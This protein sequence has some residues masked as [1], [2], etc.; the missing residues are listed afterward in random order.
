M[1]RTARRSCP[2]RWRSGQESTRRRGRACPWPVGGAAERDVTHQI[3]DL[4]EALLVETGA[5]EIPRQHALERRVV[6]LDRSHCIIDR[7]ADGRL[8]RVRFQVL[9]AR[10]PRHPK[11]TRRAIFVTVFRI[12][13]FSFLRFK[14]G[15][16]RFKR[17]GDVFKE[18][19]A[20]NDVLVFRRVHIVA[21]RVGC[22]PEFGLKAKVSGRV[23]GL[24][25]C[26]CHSSPVEN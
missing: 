23:V 19:Q 10:L 11:D 9:P 17:V 24:R 2:R 5:A 21:E 12:S 3:D 15:A 6:P 1:Y 18:Y 7:R 8:R 16:F 20:E 26:S 25:R 4:T 22:R 13:T 14:L